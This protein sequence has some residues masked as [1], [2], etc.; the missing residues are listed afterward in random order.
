MIEQQRW[1]GPVRVRRTVE[2]GRVHCPVTMRTVDI[3]GCGACPHLSDVIP[4]PDGP[5]VEI[6]CEPAL[7]VLR[8]KWT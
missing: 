4:G 5:P 7:E 2:S 3:E 6:V 8:T 1:F